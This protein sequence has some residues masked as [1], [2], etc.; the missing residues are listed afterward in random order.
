MQVT[1]PANFMR[2]VVLDPRQGFWKAEGRRFDPAPDHPV[3]PAKTPRRMSPS[4]AF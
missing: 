2:Q 4:G 3:W 1:G